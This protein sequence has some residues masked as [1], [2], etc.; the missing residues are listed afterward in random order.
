MNI[1]K[2]H[3]DVDIRPAVGTVHKCNH[4]CPGAGIVWR[5]SGIAYALRNVVLDSP[6]NGA[7]V[8][9]PWGNISKSGNTLAR[10]SLVAN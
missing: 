5:K 10:R 7:A 8:I 9:L 1:V 3:D 2:G 4:L 6:F